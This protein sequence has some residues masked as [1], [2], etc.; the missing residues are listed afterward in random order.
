MGKRS[1][2]TVDTGKCT[3]GLSSMLL[4]VQNGAATLESSLSVSYKTTH[5]PT[6]QST[7]SLLDTRPTDLKTCVHTKPAC[8]YL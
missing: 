7:V 5:T 2:Q 1:E 8:E 6:I 3:E 4:E